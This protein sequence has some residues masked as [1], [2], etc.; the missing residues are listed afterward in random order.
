[1]V[2]LSGEISDGNDTG[3]GIVL[4]GN[5]GATVNLTGTVDLTT[6]SGAA[7]AA[8]G[9]GTVNVTDNS[10]TLTTTTGK[11]LEVAN[12]TIGANGMTFRSISTNGASKGIV[13]DTTCS[14]A[15]L[16]VTGAGGT[17]T[18]GD[19]TGCSGGSI[20]NSTGSD[21]TS[22]SPV[23]T[24]IVL[25]NTKAPSLTRMLIQD[26]SNYAIRGTDVSGFTLANSVIKGTNGTNGTTPFDDSAVK[27]VNLTGSAAITDTVVS[28]GR[29]DNVSVTN[30][31]G[32]LD[33]MTLTRVNIGLNSASEG[34]DGIHLESQ[35]T[36]GA[37]KATIQ[38]TTFTGARGDLVDYSHNGTGSGDL[39]ISNSSLVNNHPGI[40]TGGGGLSLSSSGTGGNTTFDITSNTFRDAVGTGVLIVKTAGSST[41]TGT[42]SNNTIGVSGVSNSGSAEG[43]GLKLQSLGQGTMTWGVTN[44]QI[45]GY[46]DHGIEVLAGGGATPQSGNLNTTITGNTIT[47]PGDTPGKAVFPK[48]GIHFNTA[49]AVIGGAG[50]LA[51]AISSSGKE[52]SAPG[53]DFDFRLRQR[54]ATTIRL[55]ATRR[56]RTATP[57]CRTSS[58]EAT[59]RTAR[60]SA[61]RRTQFPREVASPA[62]GQG[63][64][65]APPP[66]VRGSHAGRAHAH[67]DTRWGP[68]SRLTPPRL[69][70]H[71]FNARTCDFGEDM[72]ALLPALRHEGE[73]SASTACHGSCISRGACTRGS[74]PWPGPTNGSSGAEDSP[75]SSRTPRRWPCV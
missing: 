64:H 62:T 72:C 44:N 68:L 38:D 42:F 37:L 55:P 11:A 5:A 53:S 70:H 56:R 14:T 24:G 1:M 41:Q 54:Q 50:S 32:T 74:R 46:N 36:A 39:V 22:S 6:G 10:N 33:R 49:C 17:C 7:F 26:H 59:V 65:D 66:S 13:L 8:T 75:G 57:M 28:G 73:Q 12:T 40:V 47:Q 45:R 58:S 19:T 23:G 31:S 52:G 60:L 3:G 69:V 63:A 4:T 67:A 29:E 51:N 61:K 35:S 27:F 20:L 21:D 43:S 2:T 15:G 9:G 71:L 34:N 16:T 25:K 18:S 30:S 48:N